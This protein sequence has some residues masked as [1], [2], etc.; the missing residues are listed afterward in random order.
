MTVTPGVERDGA[1]RT[2]LFV[3]AAEVLITHGMAV[4]RPAIV[5]KSSHDPSSS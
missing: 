1:G 2:D 3:I 4:H 5:Q